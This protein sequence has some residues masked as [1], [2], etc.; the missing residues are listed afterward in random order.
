LVFVAHPAG[1]PP[2]H[3][4]GQRQQVVP[5][6]LAGIKGVE[7]HQQDR[8]FDRTGG[9]QGQLALQ[10]GVAAVVEHQQVAGGGEPFL[11]GSQFCPFLAEVGEFPARL[12]AAQSHA[13]AGHHPGAGG[14]ISAGKADAALGQARR[15]QLQARA[16]Q[17]PKAGPQHHQATHQHQGRQPGFPGFPGGA[18]GGHGRAGAKCP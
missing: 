1:A 6:Q 3:F 10:L 5:A 13:A 9:G 7:A 11:G 15:H 18:A 17:Y 2:L 14:G 8:D 16:H 12:K 4:A